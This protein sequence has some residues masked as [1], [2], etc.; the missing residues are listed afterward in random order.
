MAEHVTRW[1]SCD[2]PGCTA[3][4]EP[5]QY[6]AVVRRGPMSTFRSIRDGAAV[7]GWMRTDQGDDLCKRHADRHRGRPAQPTLFPV[8]TGDHAV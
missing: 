1:L 3:T 5:D 7:M 8:P 6:R 2:F 4:F